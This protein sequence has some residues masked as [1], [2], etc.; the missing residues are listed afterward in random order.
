[1]DKK[2]VARVEGKDITQEDIQNF[3]NLLPEN[4]RGKYLTED[5][6]E[7]ITIELI[8]QELLYNDALENG[9]DKEENFANQMEMMKESYLKQYAMEKIYNSVEVSGEDIRKYYEENKDSF[10]VPLKVKAHHILLDSKEE[11]LDAIKRLNDGEDFS[12]LAKELSQCPSSQK[13]GN[14]GTFEPNQMVEPFAEAVNTMEV[15]DISQPVQSDFGFH[16]ISL[17]EKLPAR[18][19]AFEEVEDSLSAQFKILKQQESYLKKVDS[20]K[21]KYKIE[22]L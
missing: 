19:L 12:D 18:E 6:K 10:S 20:L 9:L 15:G 4:Q 1:M 21:D 22:I 7:K 14:L 3:I 8:N 5:G 11:A 13:G 16:V 17:D 2:V